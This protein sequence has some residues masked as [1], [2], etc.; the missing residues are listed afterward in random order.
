MTRRYR[1]R[2]WV[3]WL[4]TIPVTLWISTS[5]RGPE[6]G[7][8]YNYEHHYEHDYEHDYGCACSI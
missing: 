2:I 5:I 1:L 4:F 3:D 7:A 6:S 8:P